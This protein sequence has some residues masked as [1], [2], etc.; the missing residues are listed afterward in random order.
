MEYPKFFQLQFHFPLVMDKKNSTMLFLQLLK[1]HHQK[2]QLHQVHEVHER[3][4][5]TSLI[6]E[7]AFH[8]LEL[9]EL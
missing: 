4:L 3:Q 2:E 5:R 8:S 7:Q 6:T 1:Q 9:Q